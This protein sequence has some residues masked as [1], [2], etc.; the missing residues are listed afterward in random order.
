MDGNDSPWASFW[1]TVDFLRSVQ[2]AVKMS[3]LRP[4]IAAEAAK[5]YG[6]FIADPPGALQL[7]PLRT[8]PPSMDNVRPEA[9]ERVQLAIEYILREDAANAVVRESMDIYYLDLI[10]SA[11]E[12][13]APYGSDAY[14]NLKRRRMN[15]LNFLRPLREPQ[16]RPP[17]QALMK[18]EA[19]VCS[20]I[21]FYTLEEHGKYERH[22]NVVARNKAK[23]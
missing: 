22:F 20:R 18:Q 11:F 1:G 5:L 17:R 19:E 23:L 3:E 15:M 4:I 16:W 6:L 13:P 12:T 21:F 8:F 2:V 7:Q 9:R 14:V 10:K